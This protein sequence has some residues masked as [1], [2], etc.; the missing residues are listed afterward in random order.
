MKVILAMTIYK[1]INE[2]FTHESVTLLVVHSPESK[3]DGCHFFKPDE[4]CN[5]VYNCVGFKRKDQK[6]VIF[7]PIS[8]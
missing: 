6:S 4:L 7:K 2:T 1:P 3:C 5:S 8:V